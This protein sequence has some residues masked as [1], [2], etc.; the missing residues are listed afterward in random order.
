MAIYDFK[1]VPPPVKCANCWQ[2]DS[3][4][5]LIA[6]CLFKFSLVEVS[7]GQIG[8]FICDLGPCSAT[9]TWDFLLHSIKD[10]LMLTPGIEMYIP[11]FLY[12]YKGYLLNLTCYIWGRPFQISYQLT[13][14]SA[15]LSGLSSLTGSAALT[16]LAALTGE[17]C[18]FNIKNS[19]WICPPSVINDVGYAPNNA[20]VKDFTSPYFMTHQ[21]PIQ[22]LSLKPYLLYLRQTLSDFISTYQIIQ[23]HTRFDARVAD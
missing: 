17:T 12:L 10:L 5:T 6:M 1:N 11:E 7:V 16:G 3:F 9:L 23:V 18:T 14:S 2:I 20:L 22:G 15:S 8:H 19:I 4:L 13:N 21:L